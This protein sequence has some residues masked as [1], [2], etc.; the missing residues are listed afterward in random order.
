[1][2]THSTTSISTGP[3]DGADIG[4]LDSASSRWDDPATVY[5]LAGVQTHDCCG[6]PREVECGCD[7]TE[8]ARANA[9]ASRLFANPIMCRPAS[10]WSTR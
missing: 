6:L 8:V 2:T 5:D 3:I 1:M 4:T 7:P 9:S 10:K